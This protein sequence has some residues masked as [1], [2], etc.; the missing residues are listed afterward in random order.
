MRK[1]TAMK[2]TILTIFALLLCGTAT[3]GDGIDIAGDG[4][5]SVGGLEFRIGHFAP[6]WSSVRAGKENYS[7]KS[8]VDTAARSMTFDGDF[9]VS[10]GVIALREEFTRI[11]ENGLEF[12]A[13][14]R[15]E[16]GVPTEILMLGASLPLEFFQQ[17]GIRCDG[18][19]LQFEES[20]RSA[21]AVRFQEA[22]LTLESGLLHICGEKT[23]LQ[24]QNNSN[25]NSRTVSLRFW[26]VRNE[27]Q[28]RDDRLK[29]QFRFVPWKSVPV[30]LRAAANM[31]L[32]D[33]VD[34]DRRGGWTD[35]GS[36]NDM[37]LLPPGELDAGG[38][39]YCILDEKKNGGRAAIVLR[40][41]SR[42]YFP[43][44][45]SVVLPDNR[46]I[47]PRLYLLNG[48]AWVDRSAPAGTVEVEYADGTGDTFPVTPG[49]NTENFWGRRAVPGAE[50][51]WSGENNSGRVSLYS[52]AFE[53][54]AKPVVRLTFA[55]RG[56]SVWMIPAV[57]FSD[58]RSFPGLERREPAGSGPVTFAAGPDRKPF[59]DNKIKA[60][61]LLDLSSLNDAPAGKYGRVIVDGPRFVFEKRPDREVKFWGTNVCSLANIPSKENAV[62]V[63]ADL[64]R[65]GYNLLR[66][67]H[68]DNV[69]VSR[70]DGMGKTSLDPEA[71]AKMDFFLAE[72]KKRGIYLTADLYISRTFR[73][74]DIPGY[75]KAIDSSLVFKM[76]C[77]VHKPAL[78]NLKRFAANFLTHVNPHTGLAYKDDPQFLTIN[79]INEDTI[80]SG[81]SCRSARETDPFLKKRFA[82]E[83]SAYCLRRRLPENP[84]HYNGFLEELHDNLY[85]EMKAL[86]RSLGC[87]IPLADQNMCWDYNS[88]VMR[89]QYDYVDNH[90]YWAHPS[91]PGKRWRLPMVIEPQE[92]IIGHSMGTLGCIAPTQLLDKPFTVTEWCF[93]NPNPTNGEGSLLTAAFASL[94][95]WDSLN[96]FAYSHA[97]DVAYDRGQGARTCFDDVHDPVVRLGEQLGALIFR[98]GQVREA[99]QCFAIRL[100][101]DLNRSQPQVLY[102]AA[103]TRQLAMISRL[104]SV[105][106]KKGGAFSPPPGT[107]AVIRSDDGASA[108]PP[109]AGDDWNVLRSLA[110]R[111]V[112]DR[113]AVERELFRSSTGQMEWDVK[114]GTFRL[115]TTGVEAFVLP[116]ERKLSGTVFEAAAKSRFTTVA[117]VAMDGRGLGT[118]ERILLFHFFDVKNSGQRFRDGGMSTVERWGVPP[119]LAERN[120]VLLTARRDLTG[121]TLYAL[122]FDGTR[123]AAVPFSGGR[124]LLDNFCGGRV[125]AAYELVGRP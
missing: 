39:R 44:S 96:R 2:F 77:F 7:L 89:R 29:L 59:S 25:W 21:F 32:S 15:S 60:G 17:A 91:F 37:R 97:G 108:S 87:N 93:V 8:G 23:L 28:L 100:D 64:A 98:G 124:L 68:F 27:K 72:L 24:V 92:S 3:A 19:R 55:S 83:F 31:G 12:S 58:R 76:L 53:L 90:C 45:V 85:R 46:E 67:H 5:F 20:G 81:P 50:T 120:E 71:M 101:D 111:K 114:N 121:F 38:V 95:G 105:V 48:C 33:E 18:R 4:A 41:T 99:A 1:T 6:G 125:V 57:S 122:D 86:V 34:G 123:L 51:G 78:E 94:Q 10:G 112:I 117:A 26:F 119:Q 115:V 49:V 104:G 36:Q 102:A 35:Q 74:G 13:T 52:T 107:A 65:R 82:E 103:R 14:V 79:L 113:A 73:A 88:A 47:H 75:G 61:S 62:R 66:L 22:V 43:E 16:S 116:A 80:V 118:S 56:K 69:I 109:G 70:N 11:G 9:R 106:A 42:P 40:G 110:A 63:A 54:A 30:D 84:D